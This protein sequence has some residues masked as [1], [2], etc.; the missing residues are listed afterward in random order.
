MTRVVFLI[1]SLNRGGTERQLATL[2]RSLD[3]NRFDLTVL[4]F[5]TDGY[6]AKEI[7]EQGTPIISLQKRSRWDVIGFYWRLVA[8][9]RRIKP[10]IIYSFLVEP[11]L[12]TPFLK[13]F[14]P[15]TKIA[16]G[17]RA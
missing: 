6:F 16:W 1:R 7:S 12:L 13:P 3:R 17:I 4:T 10:H 9:L 14:S 2:I 5:Y 8:Q 11:N 15:A